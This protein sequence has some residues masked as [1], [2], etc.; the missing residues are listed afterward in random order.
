[1]TKFGCLLSVPDPRDYTL[2]A[3]GDYPAIFEADDVPIYDQGEIGNCVMQS[4]RSA[5]HMATGVKPGVTFGYGYW[6]SHTEQGMYPEEACNGLV[7]DGIPP[8]SIDSVEYDVPKAIEYA[9]KNKDTMLNAGKPYI[10]WQWARCNSLSD[11]KAAVY[12]STTRPGARCIVSLPYAGIAIGGYWQ[13]RGTVQGYHEMAIVGWDDTA[14]AFH[15]RNSWGTEGGMCRPEGG[16]LWVKYDYI[17]DGGGVIALIPPESATDNN[18][19]GKTD[20]NISVVRT[21]RLTT[22]YMQGDDVKHAQER[23]NVH[24]ANLTADGIFGKASYI[25]CREFQNS[26]NL[27]VDGIIGKNTLAALDADPAEP[28]TPD[29][30]E[31][32]RADFRQ[33]LF[34]QIGCIY[35]WGASGQAASNALIDSMEN[36]SGNKRRAKNFLAKQ[37]KAGYTN[38]KAY[39]CS[40]LISR[41]LQDHGLAKKKRNCNHLWAMCSAVQKTEL[42]PLDWVFRGSDDDKTHVGVYMG[43]GIVIECKG[44]DDG[45]V[46]RGIDTTTN[47]WT[48]FGHP[49]DIY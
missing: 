7:S 35:C 40:G 30:D 8:A 19:G 1:M 16:Y 9:N 10:G 18:D 21:I 49:V 25:A 20:N 22:P 48:Y 13:T 32:L 26:H 23:L 15:L 3:A 17:F 34:E 37:I 12:S 6:R 27:T 5:V 24:G 31:S 28:V 45:V 44:R 2:S 4:L 41:W 36:S 43:N 29:V 39:D 46:I 38:L 11:I 47:Y 42:E 33:Y 14:N